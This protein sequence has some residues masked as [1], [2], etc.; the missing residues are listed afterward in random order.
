M[1]IEI[2]DAPCND[3]E[4]FVIAQTRKYNSAFAPFVLGGKCI[5]QIPT[6]V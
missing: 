5:G 3:D 4:A 1:R 2:T 6:L